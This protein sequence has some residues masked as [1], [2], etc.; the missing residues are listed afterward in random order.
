MSNQLAAQGTG[1]PN[2]TVHQTMQMQAQQIV[3]PQLVTQQIVSNFWS[4]VIFEIEHGNMDFKL[5]AFP[6]A[7]VKRVM[8]LDDDLKLMISSEGPML[9]AK[10][11]DIFIAELTTRAWMH[12]EENK[13]R[14]L[15]RSDI[16]SAISKSDQYDFL[17]DIVPRDDIKGFQVMKEEGPFINHQPNVPAQYNFLPNQVTQAPQQ[18]GYYWDQQQSHQQNRDANPVDSQPFSTGLRDDPLQD[19]NRFPVAPPNDQFFVASESDQN[20][21]I[22]E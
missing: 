4:T 18:Y 14:T 21:Q 20:S 15:Q 10:A 8:K 2:N 3:H 9:F 13:R 5:H 22:N 16:S 7:R 17:I 6:L 19:S 1:Q 12:A 11:C